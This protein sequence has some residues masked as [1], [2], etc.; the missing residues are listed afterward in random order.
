[1]PKVKLSQNFVNNPPSTSKR[2]KTDYYDTLQPGLILEVRVNGRGTYYLR[3]RQHDGKTKQIKLGAVQEISL[4]EARNKATEVRQHHTTQDETPATNQITLSSFVYENYLP[5]VKL[6]KRSWE[7]DEKTLVK[8]IL[9]QWGDRE[10]GSITRA[11]IV[12]YHN[13]FARQGYKP[14]TANR[15]LA[16]VKHLFN[17][18]CKWDFIEKNPAK[19]VTPFAN[20]NTKER[21][22]ST[23]ETSRLLLAIQ[24]SP[25]PV[26]PDII[27]FLLYTG[28]RRSEALKAKWQDMDLERCIWTVPLS[29]SGK[30][31]YI[32]LSQ[33]AMEIL[34]KRLASRYPGSDYVF[35]NP[36]TGTRFKHIYNAWHSI[37]TQA[38]LQDVR[39]HDLRH[40][41]AS[42]LVNQGRSLYEVQKLLG[43][44]DS[45]TTQR[46]AHLSQESLMEAANLVGES[47]R[48]GQAA[49]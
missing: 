16:L 17:L 44:A 19:G 34:R 40:N 10:L 2:R 9:P 30:P 26:S 23:T 18:A 36:G 1:M 22:L 43:H 21:Y 27:L 31:R 5:Y 15:H 35:T 48:A 45:K 41:F 29:K 25:A 37:R 33:A 38:D 12:E 28:A 49:A 13:N 42:M 46:Y 47:I 20:P 8:K 32:P 3:C 7:F 24:Q 4:A 11:D 39:L 6:H 14:G